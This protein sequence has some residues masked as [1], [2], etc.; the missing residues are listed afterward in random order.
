MHVYFLNNN[1]DYK[2]NTFMHGHCFVMLP[3]NI[4]DINLFLF[5]ATAKLKKSCIG[6]K[7]H[8]FEKKNH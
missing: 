8:A 7:I 6:K 3:I 5:K 2:I 4:A 1:F